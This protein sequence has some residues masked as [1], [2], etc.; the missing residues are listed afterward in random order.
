MLGPG[1]GDGEGASSG[2]A[3]TDPR[4]NVSVAMPT[5]AAIAA[6]LA[7]REMSITFV[8]SASFFRRADRRLLRHTELSPL[9]REEHVS[10][11]DTRINGDNHLPR[12]D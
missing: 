10:P 2:T 1:V 12:G 6:A 8:P 11:L 4:L 5:P 3:P 7:L 9:R